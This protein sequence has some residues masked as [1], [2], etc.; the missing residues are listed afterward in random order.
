MPKVGYIQRYMLIIRQIRNNK[1]IS[2]N[3]LVNS[4]Q[5]ETIHYDIADSVGIS[6]RTIQRDLKDI[7]NSFGITIKYSKA[8]NGYYIPEDEDSETEL[9][10]IFEPFNLL[11]SSYTNG[12]LPA[13]VIEEKNKAKGSE[14]LL[15]LIHAIKHS[16][17]IDFHYSKYDDTQSIFIQVEPYVLKEFKSKWY[18]IG[19][20]KD[21]NPK[22]DSQ[23]NVWRLDSI[24]NLNVT[25][26]KFNKINHLN[27]ETEFRHSYGVYLDKDK[28][29]QEVTLSFKTTRDTFNDIKSQHC[30]QEMHI[31][32]NEEYRVRL[33]TK[34][35]YDF[36]MELLSQSENMKVI[37]PVTLKNRLIKIH[38]K[39]IEALQSEDI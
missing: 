28:E 2:L 10:Q 35:T 38:K 16:L 19:F 27:I 31:V 8:Y 30:L 23:I 15:D 13:F 21:V 14:H 26:L 12:R 32:G 29:I 7:R 22:A 20:G 34:I 5:N 25:K 9:E 33:K 36:I 1:Y 37:A 6:K 24:Q 4:I 17:L 11:D 39:A 18:L 3:D